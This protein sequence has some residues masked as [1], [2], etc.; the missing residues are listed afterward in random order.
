MTRGGGK[1]G[2]VKLGLSKRDVHLTRDGY[3]TMG[4]YCYSALISF[5]NEI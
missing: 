3:Y 5:L 1:A 2:W 4:S